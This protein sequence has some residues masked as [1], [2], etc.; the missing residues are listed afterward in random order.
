VSSLKS[1]K[2]S[3]L[4]LTAAIRRNWFHRFDGISKKTIRTSIAIFSAVALIIAGIVFQ[5]AA[6]ATNNTFDVYIDAP[7]IQNS[8]VYRDFRSDS[9][10][11]NFDGI[12]GDGIPCSSTLSG[13][14]TLSVN[15]G[16]ACVTFNVLNYSG[17]SDSGNSA[18]TAEAT[19]GGAGSSWAAVGGTGATI[20]FTSH[21]TYIGI[22]WSAGSDGNRMDFYNGN[23]IV[24]SMTTIE[25]DSRLRD[26]NLPI[27]GGDYPQQLYLGNPLYYSSS[28]SPSDYTGSTFTQASNPLA[29]S[30]AEPFVYVHFFTSG[31]ETFDRVVLSGSG[32]EF[33]N[34]VFSNAQNI[35]KDPRLEFLKSLPQGASISYDPNGGSGSMPTQAF[36]QAGTVNLR[37]N[38]SKPGCQGWC[39]ENW[40]TRKGFDLNGWT[41]SPS[42]SSPLFEDEGSYQVSGSETLYANWSP[43]RNYLHYYDFSQA[44]YLL[45]EPSF[46][47][48]EPFTTLEP[49]RDGYVFAGWYTTGLDENYL[50]FAGANEN[51]EFQK[52]E[53][54]LYSSGGSTDIYLYANW[55]HDGGMSLRVDDVS[56]TPGDI[57]NSNYSAVSSGSVFNSATQEIVAEYPT[58]TGQWYRCSSQYSWVSQ[59]ITPSENNPQPSD[60]EPIQGATGTTFNPGNSEIGFF[61]GYGVRLSFAESASDAFA[62]QTASN[63]YSSPTPSSSNLTASIP[64][65]LP[66]DPRAKHITIPSVP[67]TGGDNFT[68]CVAPSDANS[69]VLNSSNLLIEGSS[70]EFVRSNS[71][72]NVMNTETVEITGIQ[73]SAIAPQGSKY[74]RV[75]LVSGLNASCTGGTNYLVE[76]RPIGR[77]GNKKTQVSIQ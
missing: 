41:N 67:I 4:G 8:Y 24:A 29:I 5:Q 63:P 1:F 32:F 53:S 20:S 77:N 19:I 65:V 61:L 33:D 2:P 60:C 39:L 3:V 69:E 44:N 25:L 76:L 13:G 30:N 40:I 45:A 47:T 35:P 21:Q 43:S 52:Y 49:T 38:L 68:M 6:T 15:P 34:L 59:T 58:Q 14:G 75:K 66:I 71:R 9:S 56:V 57:N 42:S 54:L 55:A 17:S 62:I 70:S 73:N 48:N 22:W 46:L 64:A 28:G 16:G 11:N 27:H 18:T 37:P 36:E 74:L 10:L 50:R 23:S 12:P 7:F 51:V 31:N 72:T 26:P